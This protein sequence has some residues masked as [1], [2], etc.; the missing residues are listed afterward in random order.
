MLSSSKSLCQA[1]EAR[2]LELQHQL[3]I[4]EGVGDEKIKTKEYSEA[5]FEEAF[6]LLR[7][8]RD[9][10]MDFDFLYNWKQMEKVAA[11]P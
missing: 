3:Q 9:A 8:K 4:L 6:A 10:G 5:D 11:Y 2:A 7:L 1:A